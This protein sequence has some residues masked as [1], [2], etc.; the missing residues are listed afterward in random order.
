MNTNNK[1][2]IITGGASGLG[3]ATTRLLIDKSVI[4]F[5]LNE[6]KAKAITAELG[7]NCAYS[8]VNVTDEASVEQG[9]Q[10]T[11]DTF[12]AIH[13]CVNCAG[14]G[15]T[16]RTVGRKGPFPLD[17]FK[18]IIDLNLVGTFNVLRL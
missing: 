18:M 1:V 15:N 10:N 5:D 17:Q 4:I 9:I 14:T 12:G 2:A 13:I 6:E 8:V 11:L 16:A 7:E 3:L